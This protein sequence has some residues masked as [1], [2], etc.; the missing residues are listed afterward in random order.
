MMTET[1]RKAYE[2]SKTDAYSF[3]TDRTDGPVTAF[4]AM[5][6]AIE[7]ARRG[8][9]P[10][11]GIDDPIANALDEFLAIDSDKALLSSSER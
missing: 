1:Q 5:S 4:V 8:R 6:R 11:I 2:T 9:C 7:L 10:V 3:I